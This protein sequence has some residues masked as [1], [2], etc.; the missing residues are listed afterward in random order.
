[1][2]VQLSQVQ[3]EI[4]SDPMEVGRARGWARARLA[5]WGVAEVDEHLAETVVLL[6]SELVTNAVVHTGQ[7]AVLSLS[8]PDRSPGRGPVDGGPRPA[9]GPLRIEVADASPDAPLPRHAE[10]E[11]T[12]GR[13]LELVSGLADRWGWQREGEGKRIWCEFDGVRGGDPATAPP[14]SRTTHLVPPAAPP[15]ADAA[16]TPPHPRGGSLTLRP[17]R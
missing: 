4:G 3:F 5:G 7:P 1:V 11:D 15:P 17:T 14:S 12:G 8:H 9:V 16:P 10:G 6:V 2:S 13:G